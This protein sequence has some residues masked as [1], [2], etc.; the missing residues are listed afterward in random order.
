[1]V[2]RQM[3][4]KMRTESRG[5]STSRVR[6]TAGRAA[7]PEQDAVN[8]SGCRCARSPWVLTDMAS[9]MKARGQWIG[10][11]GDYDTNSSC[12]ASHID[13]TGP[14]HNQ[15]AGLETLHRLPLTIRGHNIRGRFRPPYN[16]ER[17]SATNTMPHDVPRTIGV[18]R[19]LRRPKGYCGA[20]DSSPDTSCVTTTKNNKTG[21]RSRRLRGRTVHGTTIWEHH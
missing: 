7:W 19:W 18:C 16:T 14:F 2:A 6:R 15:G 12:N 20:W 21:N 13:A 4:T 9:A 17:E 11:I 3:E 10:L 8:K 5:G 1:M